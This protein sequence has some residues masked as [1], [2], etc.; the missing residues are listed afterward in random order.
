MS[1][2]IVHIEVEKKF[3][4]KFF[5]LAGTGTPKELNSNEFSNAL[6]RINKKVTVS[7]EAISSVG[8]DATAGKLKVIM[9]DNVGFIMYRIKLQLTKEDCVI[10]TFNDVT[11]ALEKIR[12]EPYNFIV[13]NIL[14][15]TEREGMMFLNEM[16]SI[17]AERKVKPKI[18]ITGDA[19]R[20]E[21]M[22][23]LRES[24]INHII[25]RKPDWITKLM[26][27]IDEEKDFI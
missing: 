7:N 1:S 11:R 3:V 4:Q 18:I 15:P 23:Y 5:E 6:S 14:I 20:K 13:L 9:V 16:K 17:L 27:V 12:K 24:G 10:D 22:Q 2:D 26:E 21:L 25:E 8:E 19:I